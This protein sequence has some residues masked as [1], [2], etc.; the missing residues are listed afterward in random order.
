[1]VK[2]KLEKSEIYSTK[3]MY[4]LLSLRGVTSKRLGKMWKSKIPLK[5]KVF[6]WLAFQNHLQSG[7]ALKKK[8]NGWGVNGVFYVG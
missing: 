1:M 2:W 8:R 7:E 4:M 5:L 3:S 6:L